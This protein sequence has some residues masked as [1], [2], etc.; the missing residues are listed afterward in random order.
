MMN[1]RRVW[2]ARWRSASRCV[3]RWRWRA[4]S[5]ARTR[6]ARRRRGNSSTSWTS[7]DSTQVRAR[8]RQIRLKHELDLARL[9]VR[10]LQMTIAYVTCSACFNTSNAVREARLSLTNRATHLYNVQLYLK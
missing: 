2:A 8:P 10:R 7:P 3:R 6:C 5:S 1:R 9:S 4:R